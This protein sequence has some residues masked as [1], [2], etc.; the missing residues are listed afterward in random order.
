MNFF[1]MFESI[2]YMRFFGRVNADEVTRELKMK[3][4]VWK[5]L[6]KTPSNLSRNQRIY[7]FWVV[8]GRG[9]PHL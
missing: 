9:N 3:E 1:N 8:L 2:F 5:E 7:F 6:K 4:E